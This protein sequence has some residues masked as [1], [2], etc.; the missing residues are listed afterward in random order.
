MPT[1]LPTNREKLPTRSCRKFSW[2]FYKL[3]YNKGCHHAIPFT[4]IIQQ[5]ALSLKIA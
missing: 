2:K 4:I 5:R 1:Q 3:F